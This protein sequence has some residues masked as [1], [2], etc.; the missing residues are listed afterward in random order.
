VAKLPHLGTINAEEPFP[1]PVFS[2]WVPEEMNLKDIGETKKN[3][4]KSIYDCTAKS[5]K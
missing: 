3:H 4:S 2:L 5:L 1:F